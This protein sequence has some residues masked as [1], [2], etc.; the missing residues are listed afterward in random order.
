LSVYGT[1]FLVG[2]MA[3]AR[4]GDNAT[5]AEYLREAE[6]AARRQGRDAN[7]LWTAFGLT[8]VEIHRVNT[9]V[10]LNNIQAVLDCGLSL[11]TTALPA[12]RQVRYLLDIARVYCLTGRRDESLSVLLTAEL[13]APEQVRTHYISRQ[14]VADLLQGKFGRAPAELTSLAVRVKALEAAR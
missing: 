6:R 2:S 13:T 7:H 10:E 14:V 3:A 11:N 9:A 5:T 4:S 1:L 12:E 8:N